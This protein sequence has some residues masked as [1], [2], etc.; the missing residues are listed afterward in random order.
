MIK[1]WNLTPQIKPGVQAKH[2]CGIYL[3]LASSYVNDIHQIRD[4]FVFRVCAGD[5]SSLP[6]EAGWYNMHKRCLGQLNCSHPKGYDEESALH[7]RRNVAA[8][9]HLL[10]PVTD[11]MF[12][13]K[14]ALLFVT[15]TAVVV[16]HW[17][18]LYNQVKHLRSIKWENKVH[19]T[20]QC[21][22]RALMQ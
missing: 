8:S 9:V 17:R 21:Y 14:T 19:L 18:T 20:E 5:L 22:S 15:Q 16:G 3:R 13:N 4:P 10:Y 6:D 11:R 1:K 7:Y 2:I 12:L